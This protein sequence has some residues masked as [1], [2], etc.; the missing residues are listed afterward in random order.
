MMYFDAK[1]SKISGTEAV[2]KRPAETSGWSVKNRS[3][4]LASCGVSSRIDSSGIRMTAKISS[5]HAPKN[6]STARVARPLDPMGR[7]IDH[8]MRKKP[9][10]SMRAASNNRS[11]TIAF[12][13]AQT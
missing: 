7:T 8:M 3:P 6:C 13:R 4:M 5:F 10:P 11:C 12:P 9:A 2:M 1:A